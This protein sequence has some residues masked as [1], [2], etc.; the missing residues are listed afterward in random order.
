MNQSCMQHNKTSWFHKLMGGYAWVCNNTR[1]MVAF[2][3]LYALLIILIG[4]HTN[5]ALCYFAGTRHLCGA[6][7]LFVGLLGII[8]LIHEADHAWKY[9]WT[10]IPIG[11]LSIYFIY[12]CMIDFLWWIIETAFCLPAEVSACGT[13]ISAIASAAVVVIGY[14]NTKHIQ[15]VSYRIPLGQARKEFHIALISDLHLGAFVG[16]DHV[17]RIVTAANDLQADLIIIA[18][19]MIDDDN[20]VL[21][22]PDELNRISCKLQ[23]LRSRYGTVLTLGNHDPDATNPVF[24]SFLDRC[25]IRLLHNQIMDLPAVNVIG[26]SDSTHNKRIP[27]STLLAD[28][29]PTKPT[30]IID[31]DPR[32]M[33]AAVERKADL[34]LSGHTHAGQF[35][36][37]S[38]LTRIALGKHRFYGHHKVGRS[39]VV[40]TSGAGFFN[41]PTRI[42]TNNEIVE[43]I[44]E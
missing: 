11:I 5:Q 16:L 9:K 20:S 31:H 23:Q 6:P 38:I 13:L 21:S 44:L 27:L 17:N 1:L 26:L 42:G 40:V 2:L 43:I 12:Y 33:D 41:L 32:Y 18:G 37:A 34:I 14:R 39:H 7:Y 22:D 36:P 35:F 15:T 29:N 28:R 4:W 10:R 24:L 3:L 25:H 30:I 19:D 8:T